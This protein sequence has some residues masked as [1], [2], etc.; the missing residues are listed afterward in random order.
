[1]AEEGWIDFARVLKYFRHILEGFCK[2]GDGE[3][4]R[5]VLEDFCRDHKISQTPMG[6]L[7]QGS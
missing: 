4:G 2:E 6:G 3:G 5:R 7:L 1:M